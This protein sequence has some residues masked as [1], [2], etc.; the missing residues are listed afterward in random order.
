MREKM[1]R[2]EAFGVLSYTQIAAHLTQMA[3]KGWLLE[4]A[5]NLLWVYRRIEPKKVTFSVIYDPRASSFDPGPTEEQREFQDLC[6]HTGWVF[7][8]SLGQMQIFYNER[9]DPV[10]ID[11]DPVLQVD[12]IHKAA[13]KGYLPTWLFLLAASLMDA[14]LVAGQFVTDPIRCL[15]RSS[16]LVSVCSVAIMI[17][18]SAGELVSYF[19]WRRRAGAAAVSGEM[20]PSPDARPRQFFCLLLMLGL[21]GWYVQYLLVSNGSFWAAV[22]IAMV[23]CVLGV[24]I[25][26][27]GIKTILQEKKASRSVNRAVT[28]VLTVVLTT[29]VCAGTPAA[30]L[31]FGFSPEQTVGDSYFTSSEDGL[32]LSMSDLPG[33]E[34][35]PGSVSRWTDASPLLRR[36]EIDIPGSPGMRYTVLDVRF[37]PLYS[38]C[39]CWLLSAREDETENGQVV[40]IDHYETSDASPWGAKEAYQLR[41]STSGLIPYYLLI[42][43]RT[44]VEISFDFEP[45]AEQMAAVGEKLG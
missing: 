33:M 4:K 12:T 17:L 10:P 21:L 13:K 7:A 24:I 43:G 9:E 44:I 29:A 32:P 35:Q 30:V 16:W 23:L 15:V 3:A 5:A 22:Y 18:L 8:A 31:R 14:G 42:Y 6:A 45:T 11:T 25:A 1:R 19:L 20:I 34:D 39:R 36:Q 2:P 37:S 28:M 26:V 27:N 41:W 38:L 40:F